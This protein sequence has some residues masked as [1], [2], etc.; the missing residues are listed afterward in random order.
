MQILRYS[1]AAGLLL[2]GVLAFSRVPSE[3]RAF[4]MHLLPPLGAAQEWQGDV[5]EAPLPW[6]E[7][8]RSYLL[9]SCLNAQADP[10]LALYPQAYRDQMAG[11]CRDVAARVQS[12]N[13]SYALAPLVGAQA[14]AVLGDPDA[15][16]HLLRAAQI[17]GA[18]EGWMAAWRVLSALHYGQPEVAELTAIVQADAKTMARD[19]SQSGI[20]ASYY[21]RY[22]HWRDTIA[23]A[24]SEM[25]QAHQT[26]F[27]TQVRK[28]MAPGA[29]ARI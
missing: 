7:R 18:G 4:G 29:S 10:S 9:K 28:R 6:S 15:F 16:A 3:L 23:A 11:H 8:G 17:R 19:Y 1:L 21:V 5:A 20:L 25:P 13:P 24:I 26:Q 14:Q 27:L 12:D 22:P 2:M